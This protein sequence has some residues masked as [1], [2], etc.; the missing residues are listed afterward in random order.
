MCYGDRERRARF[1]PSLSPPFLSPISLSLSLSPFLFFVLLC[2]QC[3]LYLSVCV[4]VCRIKGS[5]LFIFVFVFGSD[6]FYAPFCFLSLSSPPLLCSHF[7]WCVCCVLFWKKTKKTLLQL[8]PF[9]F[10]VTPV[11]SHHHPLSS[12]FLSLS[13]GIVF[14]APSALFL[15]SLTILYLLLPC[16]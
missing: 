6:V 12:F 2:I 5:F 10:R 8:F 11:L 15:R 14:L 1:P 16:F 13:F 9:L 3:Y 7:V 4:C